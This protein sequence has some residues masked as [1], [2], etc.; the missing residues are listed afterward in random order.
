[1]PFPAGFNGRALTAGDIDGDGDQDVVV[2]G[3]F[4][5]AYLV[6]LNDGAGTLVP[7]AVAAAAPTPA[8][9]AKAL[10]WAVLTD[11]ADLDGDGRLDLVWTADFQEGGRYPVRLAAGRGDGT[12][13]AAGVLADGEVFARGLVTGRAYDPTGAPQVLVAAPDRGDDNLCAFTWNGAFPG[14]G[15]GCL[16][17]A[18][19][20][21]AAGAARPGHLL[22]DAGDP[23]VPELWWADPATG[24]LTARPLA[25]GLTA[26]TRT[27]AAGAAAVGV[28]DF[29]FDGDS[30]LV[31]VLPAAGRLVVLATPGRPARGAAGSGGHALRRHPRLRGRGAGLR[32]GAAAP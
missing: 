23:L 27:L 17:G 11:L 21:A 5:S 12:F 6:C 26:Q 29:D 19:L 28:G 18:G 9:A 8:P 3:L 10:P 7:Q 31:A 22:A 32:R 4:G 24:V 25:A 20:D 14:A 16:T 2:I 13:A 15:S 30:D 1:M